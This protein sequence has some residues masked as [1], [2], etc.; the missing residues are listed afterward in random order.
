[1]ALDKW[2]RWLAAAALVFLA[3]LR[4][5]VAAPLEPRVSYELVARLVAKESTGYSIEGR[6]KVSIDNHT[7]RAL[8]ELP[9]HLYMNAFREDNEATHAPFLDGRAAQTPGTQGSIEVTRLVDSRS[10][11]P[12]ELG[13][14][15]R[16]ADATTATVRLDVPIPPGQRVTFEV[17]WTVSLP[18]LSQRTGYVGDFVFAGQWFPKVAKLEPNGDWTQ[19]A[20]HPQAEFYANFGDYDVTLDVPKTHTL[21][22]S[23]SLVSSSEGERRITRF[24]AEAV[25]DFAWVAWPEFTDRTEVID[26]VAVRLLAPPGHGHNVALT[27]KTL[28]LALPWLNEWLGRYPLPT[29]TVVHPPIAANGAGGMEY[30]GL[31]TTGGA[32]LDGTFSSDIERVVIHELAHQWFYASVASNEFQS[33]FLDEGLTTFVENRAM[34]ELFGSAFDRF[35]RFWTELDQRAYAAAYGQDVAISAA[36]A[37]FPSYS[38]LAALAYDRAGLLL[39]SCSRVYGERFDRAIGVY[40]RKFR[41]AHPTPSDFLAVVDD[42]VG[43]SA[44]RNLRVGLTERGSVNFVAFDLQSRRSTDGDGYANRVLLSRHGRL[45]LPVTVDIFE[46]GRPP[47]REVWDGTGN[48]KILDFKTATPADAVCLDREQRIAIEDS[49]ADNCAT[50]GAPAVPRYWGSVLG[51]LQSLL[52]A[53]A[54]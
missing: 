19:F 45:E 4:S 21:G 51:W 47:R 27:W 24:R 2:T 5:V 50:S 43:E 53:L 22:A 10:Q 35:V 13:A 37:D 11:L 8:T 36:G 17:E 34:A 32:P 46:A 49:R 33:P 28:R 44:A 16:D 9:W 31:I 54:W 25:H 48:T 12:L 39:E 40:A 14:A 30:P 18:L 3:G 1:M 7:P 15:T 23:G 6:G 29:L 52:T 38:H 41:Q 20:F 26:G 42:Q